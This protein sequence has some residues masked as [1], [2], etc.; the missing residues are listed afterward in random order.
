MKKII[1]F[2]VGVFLICGAGL[3]LYQDMPSTLG[4][5]VD[6][7]DDVVISLEASS[8]YEVVLSDAF[9]IVKD[10]VSYADGFFIDEEVYNEYIVAAKEEEFY[11]YIDE[12]ST[13]QYDYV[14]AVYD[15]YSYD[16]IIFFK[17]F[18]TGIVLMNYESLESAK[19]MID[20]ISFEIETR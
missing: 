11:E 13:D 10:D 14:R 1:M 8:G 5:E 12:G 6:T 3:F 15:S 4:F 16:Y 18:N 2:V 7:G 9:S 17:G 20:L 19:E